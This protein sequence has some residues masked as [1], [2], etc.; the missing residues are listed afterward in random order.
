MAKEIAAQV[1]VWKK[2]EAQ[3][4]Q[5]DTGDILVPLRRVQ[6]QY[7]DKA[8]KVGVVRQP[9]LAAYY[10]EAAVNVGRLLGDS[11]ALTVQP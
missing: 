1:G 7:L 4:E 8:A 2:V 6:Q 11:L 9:E 3:V 5:T 10:Q